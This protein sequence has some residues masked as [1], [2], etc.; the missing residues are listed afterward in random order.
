MLPGLDHLAFDVSAT[1]DVNAWYGAVLKGIFNVSPATT[2]FE[3]V[4]WL[5]YVVPVLTLFVLGV[6]R[7]TPPSPTPSAPLVDVGALITP[8]TSPPVPERPLPCAHP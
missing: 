2:W 6:R 1:V 4:A 3:A 8:P 5:A 7:G